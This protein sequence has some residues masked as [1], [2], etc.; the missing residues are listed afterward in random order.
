MKLLECR[1]EF[2]YI[3]EKYINKKVKSYKFYEEKYMSYDGFVKFL[4]Q[5][6]RESQKDAEHIANLYIKK[7]EKLS[8]L[9]FSRYI[10]NRYNPKYI[11]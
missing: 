7:S 9:D 11:Q 5:V 1:E 3:F 2:R 4:M 8:F 10:V 6:Q